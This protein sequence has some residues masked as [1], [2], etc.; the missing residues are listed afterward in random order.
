MPI[1]NS[2]NGHIAEDL[3]NVGIVAMQIYFPTHYVEQKKL[4]EYDGV[5]SGKYTIGL[6][7]EQM[8]FCFSNEDAVSMALTVVKDLLDSYE[9]APEAI[10]R[11][12]VGSESNPDRSKSIK[13]HLVGMYPEAWRGCGGADCVNACFGG[14]AA[15]LN[16]LNWIESREWNGRYA[17]VVMTD[18]AEYGTGSPARPTGGAGAVALL[19]GKNAVI[20]VKRDGIVYCCENVYDFYKP[21][22]SEYPMVD[23]ALSVTCYLNSLKYCAQQYELNGHYDHV[24][25]HSPYSKLI[26]KGCKVLNEFTNG[27]D[28]T[29]RAALGLKVCRQV[30]NMYTA[31]MYGALASVLSE[32]K[33]GSRLL[34]FSYGSGLISCMFEFVIRG[35]V[36]YIL[37]AMRL[38]D[39]LD[40]RMQCSA[41]LYDRRH[42]GLDSETGFYELLT[43]NEGRREYAWR[44]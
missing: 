17:L 30:G 40:S 36:S 18:V 7:Q 34:A 24:I 12:E 31:A 11:I 26:Q 19:L 10:G 39:K 37:R 42:E 33:E 16:S 20:E 25:M 8:S 6:G 27:K 2:Q 35:D 3:E 14:T 13:T 29:S 32:C 28:W 4:E 9:I 38:E 23:G 1:T 41:E 5:S 15:L 22:S 43:V 21:N 44:V